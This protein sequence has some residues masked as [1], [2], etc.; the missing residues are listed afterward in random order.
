MTIIEAPSCPISIFMAGDLSNA[1]RI[2][3]EY[4]DE[5]GFCVTVTPTNYIYTGGEEDGFIVG[6]INY[7]RFPRA[8]QIIWQRA[9]ELAALLCDN[10][11]QQ[12]YTIQ[13]PVKAVW[14]SHRP[15]PQRDPPRCQHD[16]PS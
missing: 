7:P 16:A 14:F 9:E 4:C 1:E 6:L 10:L 11:G 3:R 8:P 15:E 5:A 12:S 13:D 2:C